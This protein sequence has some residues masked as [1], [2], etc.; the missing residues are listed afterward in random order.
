[1]RLLLREQSVEGRSFNSDLDAEP[2]DRPSDVQAEPGRVIATG[3]D[4]TR[5]SFTPAAAFETAH[6]LEEA[7]LEAEGKSKWRKE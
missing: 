5:L 3:P 1:M 6:R 2:F 7:A 4:A